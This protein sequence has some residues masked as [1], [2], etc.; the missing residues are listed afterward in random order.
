MRTVAIIQARMG[1]SRLPGK[2]LSD[3]AGKPMLAC[4]A[5]RT[6]SAET[7]DD[8]VVATTTLPGDDVI[9]DFNIAQGWGCFRGSESDVLDRYYRAALEYRADVI[10][11]VT[12]DCPLIDPQIVDQVVREFFE[13]QPGLDYASNVVPD[14]TY[15]RGLDVEV[16]SLG[17]LHRAWKEDQ[18][19]AWREHV[20]PYL[21]NHPELF[22][23]HCVTNNVDFSSMRWTVDTPEDLALVRRIYNH[24]GHANFHWQDVLGV[25]DQHQDW[26]EIN[27]QV[28]QKPV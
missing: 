10:V 21:Y 23:I 14:R 17:A 5:E 16:I 19:P 1:S 24:L 3:L 22:R 8:V 27:R 28:E 18:N 13:R 15:P 6:A 25:L 12:S 4:V 11:R 26:L 9:S 20:T 2:V 7:V